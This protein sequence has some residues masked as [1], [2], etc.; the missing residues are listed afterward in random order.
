MHE[1]S[2]IR[3]EEVRVESLPGQWSTLTPAE[4]HKIPITERV[5]LILGRKIRFFANG[6]EVSALDALMD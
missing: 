6:A 3:F 4:F 2:L 1:A 5:Q